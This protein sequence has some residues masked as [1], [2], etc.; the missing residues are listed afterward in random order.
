MGFA[1]FMNFSACYLDGVIIL[2]FYFAAKLL[3][4]K[5]NSNSNL[6]I[7]IICSENVYKQVQ[8][9]KALCVF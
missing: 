6:F 8:E 9:R 4:S 3:N 7:I 5:G 1:H 2:D